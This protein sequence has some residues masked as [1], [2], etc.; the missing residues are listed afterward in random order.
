[1]ITIELHDGDI[2]IYGRGGFRTQHA[3]EQHLDELRQEAHAHSR[4]HSGELDSYRI[5]ITQHTGCDGMGCP[6]EMGLAPDCHTLA[7]HHITDSL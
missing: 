2:D 4:R 1:M 5:T 3:A 6:D 7:E